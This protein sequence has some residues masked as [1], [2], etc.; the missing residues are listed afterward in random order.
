MLEQT[1][2]K[3][4][5]LA[6]TYIARDLICL[7]E[8]DRI[9]TVQEYA[10]R[11]GLSRGIIQ[12]AL[13]QLELQKAVRL[14]KL[15]KTGSF[16][17]E[18][19]WEQLFLC[20]D[21]EYITG[22][23]PPPLTHQYGALATGVCEVMANCPATF[24][25]SFMHSGRSRAKALSRSIYDFAIVS[26]NT[27]KQLIQFDDSLSIAMVLSDCI[28]GQPFQLVSTFPPGAQFPSKAKIAA[29]PNSPDQYSI[30]CK[31]AQENH[32]F[33]VHSPYMNIANLLRQG[34]ANFTVTRKDETAAYAGSMQLF[35]LDDL[36]NSD[37]TIPAVLVNR[38]NYGIAKILQKYLRSDTIA[39][40]QK[41][42]LE[43]RREVSF[44]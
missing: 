19:N 11:F 2:F 25:F 28:Y 34:T 13:Q 31:W 36:Q 4:S 21:L 12:N 6:V 35:P 43:N 16:V 42:V 5:W 39:D 22:S 3:K 17:R 24:N 27:A 18:Q 29:D 7:Q 30:A 10:E 15:G 9:P 33:L 20:A 23:M 1:P 40:V 38:S 32:V 14:E 41:Q 26:L 44:Y 8:G 37:M